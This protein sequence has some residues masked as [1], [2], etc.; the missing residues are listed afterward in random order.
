[1]NKN[2]F[3]LVEIMVV[4]LIIAIL[5]TLSI[6]ALRNARV[7]TR[8]AQRKSDLE[9]IKQGLEIYRTDCSDFPRP[10][11]A[12]DIL[13][14]FGTNLIGDDTPPGCST[15][16]F[17]I[18]SVPDDLDPGRRYYYSQN[19]PYEYV[20]CA[21]LEEN[22]AVSTCPVNANCGGGGGNTCDWGFSYP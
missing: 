11:Q 9:R 17:Y 22:P 7:Q 5:S 6:F 19:S 16:N 12:G 13:V 20:L 18:R 21:N 1:M 14:L 4:M 10:F 15:S 3:T 8:D 2:G